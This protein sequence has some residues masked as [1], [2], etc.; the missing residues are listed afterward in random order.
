MKL[1]NRIRMLMLR[2]KVPEFVLNAFDR[3][4]SDEELENNLPNPDKFLKKADFEKMIEEGFLDKWFEKKS[5]KE[6]ASRDRGADE[7]TGD[8]A[9]LYGHRLGSDDP[10]YGTAAD[11]NSPDYDRYQ[12]ALKAEYEVN[13]RRM[14]GAGSHSAEDSGDEE[15]G[16]SEEQKEERKRKRLNEI[17]DGAY[18][19][20]GR[21]PKFHAH[22]TITGEFSKPASPS[23]INKTNREFW[24]KKK[25]S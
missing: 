16:L 10:R 15:E 5:A 20:R 11:P 8:A 2:N 19:S 6:G 3:A 24:D 21:K 12:E 17:M 1:K 14:E 7:H 9:D 13:R 4:I 18:G 23:A 25:K 22:K